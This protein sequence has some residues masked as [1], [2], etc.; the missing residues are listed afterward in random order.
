MPAR[1][2]SAPVTAAPADP[3]AALA[4][5]DR[6]SA[7]FEVLTLAGP[8]RD[9]R[10]T[11]TVRLAK[12]G[13]VRVEVDRFR[14]RAVSDPWQG[15]GNGSVA[16][17]GADG[18]GHFLTRHPQSSQYRKAETAA[19]ESLLGS[20]APVMRGFFAADSASPALRPAGEQTWEG[21][22]YRVY[23]A[24]GPDG[25]KKTLYVSPADG[26]VHRAV[27]VS[28]A[29]SG[30][31]GGTVTRDIALRNVHVGA[32][33]EK[34]TGA[35]TFAYTPP[36]DA[37]PVAAKPK[38]DAAGT[39][40]VGDPA[41][42]F[43][44]EDR[45]GKPVRFSEVAKGRVTVLKFWATWCWPCNQSLPETEQIAASHAAAGPDGVSVLAVA[46]WDS[47]DAFRSWLDRKGKDNAHIRFAFDPAPQ[48]E[49]AG[50]RL[51]RVAATPTAFVVGKDGRI[52]AVIT[53]YSGPTPALADAVN[54]ALGAAATATASAAG[55]SPAR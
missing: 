6:L 7:D 5:A 32:A 50:S 39:L 22:R 47:R 31:T 30:G 3:A 40:A 54:R 13:L 52:A 36:A 26:L 16:V 9:L 38:A 29:K 18:A 14:R 23:E 21:A 1:A 8:F 4:R 2:Q 25:E 24:D 55:A 12:P 53:G 42:D 43:T 48:G 19:P 45:D 15:S 33:A 10:E 37:L 49:D 51:Y 11:G 34:E 46:L 44:V 27:I 41:P 28:A 17:R 35:A 20:L